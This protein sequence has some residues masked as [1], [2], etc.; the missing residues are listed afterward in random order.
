VLGDGFGDPTHLAIV[1]LVPLAAAAAARALYSLAT[2]AP[3][4]Y[5]LLI[6]ALGTFLI[7]L[8]LLKATGSVGLVYVAAT[9]LGASASGAHYN[10]AITLTHYLRDEI[11][12]ADA[13][14][15]AG[16]QLAGAFGAA[17]V[18]AGSQDVSGA[19]AGADVPLVVFTAEVLFS[20]ALCLAHV[21]VLAAQGAGTGKSGN[22]YF[23]LAM[24]FTYY[25]GEQTVAVVAR[26]LF[27][28]ALGLAFY[29]ADAAVDMSL[30][31]SNRIVPYVLAPLLAAFL[32]ER[33]YRSQVGT[34]TG[35]LT[36]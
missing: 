18:V 35:P 23:G 20:F 25:G 21:N 10:P 22:G 3:D 32:A 26:G 11:S 31:A 24:G 8:T 34:T 15:Y 14:K 28:P 2:S 4:V 36:A 9:F 7:G 29:L 12:A 19:G 16:A 6:E 30:P 33:A 5:K 27:N 1:V 17:M 13:A